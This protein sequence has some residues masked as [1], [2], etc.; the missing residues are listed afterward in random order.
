MAPKKLTQKATPKSVAQKV[1]ELKT[2]PVCI[3]GLEGKALSDA[4]RYGVKRAG[5][6]AQQIFDDRFKSKKNDCPDKIKFMRDILSKNFSATEWAITRNHKHVE[7]KQRLDHWGLLEGA[8][9]H[10]G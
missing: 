8:R 5:P 7:K 10:Q 4:M 9:R 6:E 2:E 3:N 1:K